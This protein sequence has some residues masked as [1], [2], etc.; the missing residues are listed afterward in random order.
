MPSSRKNEII[1][2]KA[3]F[4]ESWDGMVVLRLDGSPY[5]VKEL[6]RNRVE[7]RASHQGAQ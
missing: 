1:L 2:W 6:G 7:A 5:R 3:L 4:E